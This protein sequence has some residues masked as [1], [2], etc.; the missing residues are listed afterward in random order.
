MSTYIKVIIDGLFAAKIQS[1]QLVTHKKSQA[2]TLWCSKL[3]TIETI[4]SIATKNEQ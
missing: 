4:V 1:L 3:I 2:H